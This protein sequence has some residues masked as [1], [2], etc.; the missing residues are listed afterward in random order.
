MRTLPFRP[1]VRWKQCEK[2]REKKKDISAHK[3]LRAKRASRDITNAS[4]RKS[5]I[6]CETRRF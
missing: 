2:W 5:Q 1:S 6:L 4:F 3:D